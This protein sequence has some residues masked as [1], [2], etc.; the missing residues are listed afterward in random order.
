MGLHAHVD[1][2]ATRPFSYRQWHSCYC[3]ASGSRSALPVTAPWGTSNDD[4]WKDDNERTHATYGMHMRCGLVSGGVATRS[5]HPSA[6]GH[7]SA[8]VNA[9]RC[10][11][12]GGDPR[13]TTAVI[14]LFVVL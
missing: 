9:Q 7:L 14:T 12:Q 11:Q 3:V 5:M 1:Q 4:I 2:Q 13:Y 8:N 10:R 6:V